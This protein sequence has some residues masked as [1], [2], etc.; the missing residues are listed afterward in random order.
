MMRSSQSSFARGGSQQ[1]GFNAA[2]VAPGRRLA[3]RGPVRA[4]AA[5][6]QWEPPSTAKT[7]PYTSASGR[8]T[9]VGPRDMYEGTTGTDVLAMQKDLVAEGYLSPS[10]ASGCVCFERRARYD[11]VYPRAGAAPLPSYITR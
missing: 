7:S 6:P 5:R 11:L 2:V 3:A 9:H 4:A 8:D 1:G 10:D